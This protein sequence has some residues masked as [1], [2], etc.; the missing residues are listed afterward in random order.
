MPN[1]ATQDIMESIRKENDIVEIVS[2]YV[3]LKKQGRNYFGL[4]PFHSENTPSFSVNQDK[5]IFYCFGC[6][7]GGNVITFMME[8]EGFPFQQAVQYLAEKSGITLPTQATFQHQKEN[9][10]E[11]QSVL[12]AFQWLT[13]LYHHL[14]RHTKD[15][16]NALYYL[17]D[18]GFTDEAIDLFQ[19]GYS[20]V[21]KEFVVQFLEKKGFHRQVMVNAGL[22]TTSESQEYYDRFQGRVIFPIR[23]HIGKTIGFGGRSIHNQEPKYLNS[24]E[25]RLFQKSKL[26]YNFDVARSEIRRQSEA[27]LF[28][29]YVDVIAAHQ[30]GIKNGVASLGTSL[31]EAHA[32]MLRRY[33]DTVLICYDGDSAGQEASYKAMRQLKRAGCTVKIGNLPTSYDPDQYIQEFGA[34]A[35]KS[36]VIKSSYSDMAFLMHY[37]KKDFNLQ[38]EAERIQYVEKIVG[39]IARLNSPIERD[40]YLRELSDQFHLSYDALNQD[41]MSRIRK[42]ENSYD[43]QKRFGNTNDGKP[44]NKT[45][46]NRVY[47]AFHNAE[48]Q[49]ISYM[50]QNEHIAE[51]VKDEIG[52]KFNVEQHQVIVTLLYGFYE[53]GNYPDPSHFLSFIDDPEIQ[54]LVV[55]LSMLDSNWE[56]TEK[57]MD[58]YIRLILAEQTDYAVIKKLEQEQKE[59]E[60]SDPKKAAQIAMEILKIKQQSKKGS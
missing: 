1:Q 46:T 42:N 20:P 57:E 37:W 30:A 14:L 39:E 15:G 16:K 40:H 3:Q 8:M 52:S 32:S 49:L 13:K 22:L 17:Y 34:E 55:E 53:E 54:K 2:E 56:I 23:N 48:R 36:Q 24:P 33:V 9:S 41:L 4:C 26:L 31:T 58:D 35:F 59:V 50:L 29:G 5:Q 18:R 38:Q 21:S 47:R 51:R 43:N 10:T 7:K 45:D 25:S 19:V 12:E 28:E 44:E 60:K 11:D 6:K 27:I